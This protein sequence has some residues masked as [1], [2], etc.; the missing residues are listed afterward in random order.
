MGKSERDQQ[1]TREHP[2]ADKPASES[3]SSHGLP[4]GVWVTGLMVLVVLLL[5]VFALV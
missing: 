4:P 5:A 2:E 3:A 1:E